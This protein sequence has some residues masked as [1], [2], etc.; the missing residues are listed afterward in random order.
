MSDT[1]KELCQY[2]AA[3]TIW[4]CCILWKGDEADFSQC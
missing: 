2:V 1:S 3:N 4:N